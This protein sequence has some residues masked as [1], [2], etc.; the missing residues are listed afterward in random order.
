[1]AGAEIGALSLGA[2]GALRRQHAVAVRHQQLGRQGLLHPVVRLEREVVP[3]DRRPVQHAVQALVD[4]AARTV[5]AGDVHLVRVG[6]GVGCAQAQAQVLR[7]RTS[8]VDAQL[9]GVAAIGILGPGVAGVGRAAP[10]RG[11]LAGDDVDDPAHG[12]GAIKRRHRPAHHLDAL[13]HVGRDPVQI[14]AAQVGAIADVARVA[15]ATPVHQ[16]QGVVVRQ[17][18]NGD[19]GHGAGGADAAG[20]AGQTAQQFAQALDRLSL[21][22]FARD[23][24]DRSRSV[25]DI[26]ACPGSG[27]DDIRDGGGLGLVGGIVRQDR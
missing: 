11:D 5:G 16:H 2:K 25:A 12:V 27:D 14:L 8:H 26:D 6:A 7:E 10:R 22:L 1:M 24:A 13:D 15:D 19:L 20:H 4:D 23:D 17:A 21:D 18:A 9:I 3:V